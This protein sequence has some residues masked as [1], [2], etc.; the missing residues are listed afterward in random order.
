MRKFLLLL[1]LGIT[2]AAC[3]NHDDPKPESGPHKGRTVL[4]YLISNNREGVDLDSDLKSNILTM[5]EG[6]A[7]MHEARSL[8]VYYRPKPNDSYFTTPSIIKYETDGKGRVN[9]K[10]ALS[11]NN[12]TIANVLEE[13]VLVKQYEDEVETPHIATDPEQMTLV[14]KDMVGAVPSESYGL[15][16][17]SHG[18]G[19]LPGN[20]TVR[21]FGD[22]NA[23]SVNIPEL[24]EAL[25]Q[26]H[27]SKFDFI[28][29]DACLMGSVEVMYGLR[30]VTKYCISSPQEIP[31]W[32]F[33]YTSVLPLLYS[34]DFARAAKDVCDQYIANNED[35]RGWGT[36]TCADCTSMDAFAGILKEELLAHKD[37]LAGFDYKQ[38]EQY[39][40]SYFKYM[41]CDL[42][43]FVEVLNG[44]VV[45]SALKEAFDK[46]VLYTNS[47]DSYYT[48]YEIEQ[49]HYSG[50][51]IYIPSKNQK[52]SWNHYFQTLDWYT[53]AGW[54]QIGWNN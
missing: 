22:D 36:I 24:A 47:M 50:M 52:A 26:S 19:W 41:S 32:G 8:V 46:V 14:V 20:Q 7:S 38:L 23:W 6:L 44:G 34:D 28:L 9:G 45:P 30:N 27:S 42:L 21:S 39:G 17:G 13:A 16:F 15:V 49:E 2:M 43:Q 10:S 5:Y 12:L 51:G 54:D 29:F 1:C 40:G 37:R 31:T 4:A 33:P 53:E 48:Q 18:T 3:N 11:G 25:S 35:R